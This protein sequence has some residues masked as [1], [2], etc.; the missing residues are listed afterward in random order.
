MDDRAAE[1]AFEAALAGRPGSADAR[2][3]T[4][5]TDAL[6]AEATTPG[7]PTAALAELLATGLLADPS[8]TTVGRSAPASR[9][10]RPMI[11]TSLVAK[12]AAAGAVAKASVA[13]G[14]VAALALTG[15]ATDVL[16]LP[17]DDPAVVTS[18][19]TSEPVPA[20][21]GA[22]VVDEDDTTDGLPAGGG[23]EATGAE[24]IDEE[25]TGEEP[26]PDPGQVPVTAETWA[27]GPQGTQS[28]GQW[29]SAGAGA[30]VIRGEVVSCFAQVRNGHRAAE[31]CAPVA[32]APVHEQ[33]MPVVEDDT[34]GTEPAPAPVA[35][36]STTTTGGG[37]GNGGGNGSGNGAG[38]G[39]GNGNGGGNGHGNGGGPR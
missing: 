30:G 21:E 17:G 15:A 23:E 27:Q 9:K 34:T 3:L 8:R 37:H 16:P 32:P 24:A 11:L 22:V 20:D 12:F 33:P 26:T 39:S 1:E 5:F 6:R 19:A 31:D 7:R 14:A 18:G 4:A 28:F 29:V 25:A 13:G 35:P 2:A 36:S 10:R 38:N